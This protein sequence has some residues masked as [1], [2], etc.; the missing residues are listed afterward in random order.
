MLKVDITQAFVGASAI[1]R[2]GLLTG[3]L[4]CKV[5]KTIC[6]PARAPLYSS[7]HNYS[8]EISD[9]DDEE[10]EMDCCCDHCSE[11]YSQLPEPPPLYDCS[12]AHP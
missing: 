8:S 6:Y 4:L 7:E 3:R 11:F 5:A 10:E 2:I 12:E 9:F 1:F